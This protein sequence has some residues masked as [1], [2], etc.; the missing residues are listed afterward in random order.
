[1][2]VSTI[3]KKLVSVSL[4]FTPLAAALDKNNQLI[5]LNSYN[6]SKDNTFTTQYSS[7]KCDAYEYTQNCNSDTSSSST[8]SAPRRMIMSEKFIIPITRECHW[9]KKALA[10]REE[11][12][13]KARDI[14][15]QLLS[16]GKISC[17]N[18]FPK[19]KKEM[20][21]LFEELAKFIAVTSDKKR[22][23]VYQMIDFALRNNCPE[24]A[25]LREIACIQDIENKKKKRDIDIMISIYAII[26]G[27]SIISL[28]GVIAA[29][30]QGNIFN[31]KEKKKLTTTAV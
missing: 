7:K 3:A 17:P 25:K 24:Y 14:M 20:K 21:T 6:N 4:F 23:E 9:T 26:G 30:I 19:T 15:K 29:C 1:M 28:V 27:G 11:M 2:R 5:N 22:E 10:H 31:Y 8:F 18:Y 16:N 12:R 13:N